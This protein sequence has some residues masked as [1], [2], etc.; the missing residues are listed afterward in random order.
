[1]AAKGLLALLAVFCL[2]VGLL[3][4]AKSRPANADTP[5]FI[6]HLPNRHAEA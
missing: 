4:F 6:N 5:V 2:L 1:M 3:L